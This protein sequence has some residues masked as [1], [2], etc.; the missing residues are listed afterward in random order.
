M[1]KIHKKLTENELENVIDNMVDKANIKFHQRNK[2]Y[3][4]GA[5]SR[6]F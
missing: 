4:A 5:E 3:T 2:S 6:I 1:K